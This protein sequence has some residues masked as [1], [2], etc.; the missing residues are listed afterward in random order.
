MDM[1]D[2]F[3]SA[4]QLLSP[5]LQDALLHLSRA[6]QLLAEEIRLRAGQSP[7][8]LF[9]NGERVLYESAITN[10]EL[11][12][13]LERASCGSMHAVTDQ[14]RS[15][16]LS[17]R[18]GVRVGVCGT[19]VC[20]GTIQCLREIS[21]VAIRIPRQNKTVGREIIPQLLDRSVLIVSPPGG[22][23]TTLLR[24]LVRT[25]S[26]SG[27]RVSLCDERGEIAACHCGVPQFDVGRC[28][29]VLS[30]APKAEAA[31]LLLRAMNPQI[32]AMDEVSTPR[33]ADVI[34]QILG[35]GVQIFATAHARD[36]L[37]LR[38]R[39]IYR[40]ILG[41]AAFDALVC[42]SGRGERKYTVESI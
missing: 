35:C 6:Q 20:D 17:A 24:E 29:D 42:I 3:Y 38:A 40:E 16:F 15:G 18:G 5:K 1:P 37:D 27:R 8:V 9:P 30:A 34:R 33:D 11:L 14:L 41:L 10:A 13:V 21:S 36:A 23:K 26:D 19:A 32:I 2:G 31:A 25:A 7:S 4:L 22:G 28:T 12:D 39:P